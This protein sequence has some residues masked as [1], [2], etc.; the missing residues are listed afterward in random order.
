MP[1]ILLNIIFKC[2]CEDVSRFEWVDSVKQFALC[3]VDGI[4]QSVEGLNKTKA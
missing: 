1:D 2:V 3:I 4:L